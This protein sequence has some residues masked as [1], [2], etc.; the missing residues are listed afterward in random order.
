[1]QRAAI[2][3][4]LMLGG[5]IGVPTVASAKAK[6]L[7]KK[8]VIALIKMYA[9]AGPTGATGLTGPMGPAGPRGPLHDVRTLHFAGIS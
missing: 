3:G 7:T 4:V 5:A 9:K 6:P 2:A 1:M 8:Q